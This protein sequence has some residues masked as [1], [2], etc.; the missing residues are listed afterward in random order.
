M[1]DM[2]YR[3]PEIDCSDW[4][5][6]YPFRLDHLAELINTLRTKYGDA[7]AIR[8]DAGYN[9]IT[10]RI[11]PISSD[12]S[13]NLSSLQVGEIGVFIHGPLSGQR[14]IVTDQDRSS[15]SLSI[16][17]IRIDNGTLKGQPRTF[18]PSYGDQEVVRIGRGKVKT[19]ISWT[20]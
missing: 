15:Q 9:N 16:T 19:Q 2:V 5:G 20:E 7:A 14:F 3:Q 4:R 11:A 17:E 8:F 12:V 10:V 13:V 1:S 6:D 18:V